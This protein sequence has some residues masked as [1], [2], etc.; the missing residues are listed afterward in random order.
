MLLG[1]RGLDSGVKR[2]GQCDLAFATI[3]AAQTLLAKMIVAGVL[4]APRTNAGRFLGADTAHEGH[5]F[6]L[7]CFR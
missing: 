6:F 5:L 7:S 2:I 3:T 4:G 1:S